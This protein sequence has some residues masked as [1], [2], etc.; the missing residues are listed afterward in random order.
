MSPQDKSEPDVPSESPDQAGAEIV[1]GDWW[2]DD[3]CSPYL[4]A[5]F[6]SP[7]KSSR[8]IVRAFNPGCTRQKNSM[9]IRVGADILLR[10]DE[11]AIEEWIEVDQPL[12]EHYL[13]GRVCDISLRT[14]KPWSPEGGD[15]RV[16]GLVLV[17]WRLET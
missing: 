14:L 16:M 1:C 8:L 4:R 11:A 9:I 7:E 2:E 3:W 12:P 6:Q 17:D 5:R 15:T 13:D 10:T